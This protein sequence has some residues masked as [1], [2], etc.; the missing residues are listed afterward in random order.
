MMNT[1]IQSGLVDPRAYE[2]LTDWLAPRRKEDGISFLT[3]VSAIY[4]K[5]GVFSMGLHRKVE[6]GEFRYVVE[7]KIPLDLSLDDY[8]GARQIQALFNKSTW[9]DL[10]YNPLLE[11]VKAFLSYLMKKN[12]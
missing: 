3:A 8:R 4:S 7:E 2:G 11:G 10:G 1:F 5:R 12:P 9:I 6:A